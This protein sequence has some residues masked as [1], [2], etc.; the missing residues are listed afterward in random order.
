MYKQYTSSVCGNIKFVYHTCNT[1]FNYS[2]ITVE[3]PNLIIQK[4]KKKLNTIA[5]V[6]QQQISYLMILIDK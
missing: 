6:A 5:D 4:R 2:S 1:R 3:N